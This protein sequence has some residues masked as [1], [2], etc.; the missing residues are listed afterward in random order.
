[1]KSQNSW[2]VYILRC[3][4]GSLYT[5][6]TNRIEHRLNAHTQGTGSRFVRSHLPFELAKTIPCSTEREARWLEYRIKNLN[7]ANKIKL[8]SM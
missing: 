3:E 5:G 7:R 1:M 4:N 8:L 2:C 6:I